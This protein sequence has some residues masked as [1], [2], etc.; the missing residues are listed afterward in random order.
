[1]VRPLTKR[2]KNGTAYIRRPHVQQ[3][4]DALTALDVRAILERLTIVD[5]GHVDYV[6]N[7]C[8]VHLLREAQRRGDNRILNALVKV[9]RNRAALAFR[10]VIRGGGSH[11]KALRENALSNFDMLIARG[12]EPGSERLDYLEVSFDNAIVTLGKD[13]FEAEGRRTKSL[14]ELRVPSVE[15]EGDEPEV[16]FAAPVSEIAAALRMQES[17]F[18]AFRK[19]RIRSINVLPTE[20]RD[21]I[22]LL[23]FHGLA[24]GSKDPDMDTI[25]K[26]MGVDESTV[27]YRIRRGIERLKEQGPT[28]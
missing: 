24:I 11:E 7:E 28:P 17:E 20:Q 10:R 25:A 13:L 9:V 23:L 16:E 27:R 14:V 4:L 21:A 5:R 2:K 19:E 15:D 26:R 8:V 6:A 12:L 3:A 18:A 22:I 1:M